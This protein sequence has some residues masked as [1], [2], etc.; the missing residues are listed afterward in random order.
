MFSRHYI[1]VP[2]HHCLTCGKVFI[3]NQTL[4]VY[5]KTFG[6]FLLRRNDDVNFDNTIYD[7]FREKSNLYK[8]G[9]N[10]Q[11]FGMAEADRHS[12][13]KRLIDSKQMD[14]SS[15]CSDIN[16]DI[17]RFQYVPRYFDAVEKWK[18]DLKFI[19][20]YVKTLHSSGE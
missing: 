20:D 19:G 13:L 18:S 12:L 17:N 5:T 8:T 11:R 4:N 1:D 16:D 15:I 10:V 7:S 14:Y 3:G 9:Y 6:M 2:V